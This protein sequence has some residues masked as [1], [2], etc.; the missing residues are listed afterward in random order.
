MLAVA[1]GSQQ[2]TQAM[3]AL[4]GLFLVGVEGVT[5]VWLVRH[6]DCYQGLTDP[7]DPPLSALG[8]EQAARLAARVRRMQPTAVYS[9]PS[10]RALETAHAIT[11]ELRVDHR[12]IEMALEVGA[13]GSLDLKEA[14]S[15]VIERM[16]SAID[17]V[18]QA[19]AGGRIVMVGHGAAIVA[20]LTSVLRLEPGQLRILPH[21][22]S[23]SVVRALDDRRMV[24]AIGDAA[25]LE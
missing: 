12:L 5:E 19:H 10:R 13:D 3:R 17:Q 1:A 4:E 9:S 6:A 2:L 22:T 7:L 11:D 24:G 15:G 14:P 25:H 18:A 8:R 20:Y 23:I 16:T 21:Y